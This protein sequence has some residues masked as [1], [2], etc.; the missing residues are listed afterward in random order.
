MVQEKI[1]D[2]I[3]SDLHLGLSVCRTD[4]ALG[5]LERYDFERLLILGDLFD[6]SHALISP[7]HLAVLDRIRVCSRGDGCDVVW[8]PGNHDFARYLCLADAF[9]ARVQEGP[10][11]WERDSS[12]LVAYHGHEF[13][14]VL[15]SSL[16][17]G[18][19]ASHGYPLLQWLDMRL[20][21]F[22]VGNRHAQPL[23]SFAKFLADKVLRLSEQVAQRAVCAARQHDC[24]HVLC[25]H[26][27]IPMDKQ[28]GLVRYINTGGFCEA[29]VTYATVSNVGVQLH[30]I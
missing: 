6:G 25:G 28:F 23:S 3:I 11:F 24:T 1:Y 19:F 5:V 29:E 30:S 26:T 17:P 22:F 18:F 2:L 13:D 14:H 12:R 15:S 7:S 20:F 9:G 21:H 4:D 27:H 10:F 8:V 16:I